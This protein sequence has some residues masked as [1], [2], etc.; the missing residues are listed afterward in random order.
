MNEIMNEDDVRWIWNRLQGVI[1]SAEEERGIHPGLV[2]WSYLRFSTSL[3]FQ[4]FPDPGVATMMALD[5][6]MGTIREHEQ[7]QSEETGPARTADGMPDEETATGTPAG[8]V[9]Q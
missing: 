8:I 6:L 2:T 9:L 3:H 1:K 4:R 7:E 5:I